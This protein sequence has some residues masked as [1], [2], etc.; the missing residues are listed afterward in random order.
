[1]SGEE[2]KIAVCTNLQ[3]EEQSGSEKVVFLY[4]HALDF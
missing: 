3:C 1:M 4:L 2:K